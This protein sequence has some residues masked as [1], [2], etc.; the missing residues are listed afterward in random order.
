MAFRCV[1]GAWI[2]AWVTAVFL[3]SLLIAYM[4]MSP[5]AA[6]IGT[7]FDRLPATAWKVADDIGPA[8]KLMIG[9]LLLFGLLLLDRVSGLTRTMRYLI[10]GAIGV[11]AVAA[12]IAF[13]PESLSRGFAIGLTGHRFDV[14]ATSIYLFGGVVAGPVFETVVARCRKRLAA[15]RSLASP[16]S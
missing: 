11:G 9:G 12:T 13:L 14:A 4:G 3:P 5:G 6:A 15:G 7:G 10:G 8:A 16:R 2:G 1:F